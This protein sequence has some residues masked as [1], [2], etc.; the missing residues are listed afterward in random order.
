MSVLSIDLE[1]YSSVDLKT[2]GT[3]AY[4]EAEDF[5]ILLFAYKFDDEPTVCVDMTKDELPSRVFE[6]LRDASITKRAFNAQFE[7]LCI[8]RHFA[9]NILPEQWHCTMVHSAY[10]GLPL[11]LA[12]VA[13][14]MKLPIQ[15]DAAGGAL[16][17]YFCVPQKA[18][19][20][21]AGRVRN[22][23]E[24]APEKW[25]AFIQYCITD[26]DTEVAL[27][28]KLAAFPIPEKER[29]LWALDQRINDR[30]ITLDRAL[31]QNAVT[32]DAANK[33]ALI[34]EARKLSGLQNPGSVKQL[35]TWLNQQIDDETDITTLRKKDMPLIRKMLPG[36]TNEDIITRMLDI[37]AE[38][39]KT[40]VKKYVAMLKS[41]CRDGRVRGLLQFYGAN[42][43][44]R[45]AGRIIQVHNLPRILVK[46]NILHCFREA[47]LEGDVELLHNS[48]ADLLSQLIRTALTAGAGKHLKIADFA[49]IEARVIAWLAGEQWRLDVFR[50]HGKIYEASAAQMF[51][52]PLG[53]ISY[54]DANGNT[55]EGENYSMRQR[56]KVA[57]LALGYQGGENALI[58]MGAIEMGV[59]ASELKG[60]V[61]AWRDANPEIVQLWYDTQDAAIN[62]IESGQRVPLRKGITFHME[63]GIMF[64][65]LP[66]G[67]RLSYMRAKIYSK[68]FVK[69][70]DVKS[71][72]YKHISVEDAQEATAG[73]KF[74]LAGEPYKRKSIVYEGLNQETKKWGAVYTYGGKLV[75]NI[76]QAIARDCLAETLLKLDDEKYR[77]VMHVHDEVVIE[78]NDD[79]LRTCHEIDVLMGT[80]PDWAPDMPL[81]AESYESFYYKKG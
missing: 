36:Q 39:S 40:S 23:P 18:T 60:I 27:A 7:R 45:W 70:K 3:Y 24:H 50:T 62:A 55:V 64:I 20:T 53:S 57:E 47:L 37:R 10:L 63:K 67:R 43:T 25:A 73:S 4:V 21:N 74:V 13:H 77:T 79:D 5:T 17:R 26:V 65:T 68:W 46:P 44:G 1:T 12:Q 42:R 81:K 78:C 61:K 51:K 69:V 22:M 71:G 19:K 2:C 9:I 56:G 30:G 80:P 28:E 15:K 11:A 54:K 49:A 75:E 66:S 48:V 38:T 14:V 34:E 52:V 41:V 29:R 59:P 6:A 72:D 76:V 32:V 8:N 16:I 35:L 58:T 33:S 31:A